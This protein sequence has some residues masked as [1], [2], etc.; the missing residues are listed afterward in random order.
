MSLFCW[1]MSSFLSFFPKNNTWLELLRHTVSVQAYSTTSSWHFLLLMPCTPAVTGW[2]HCWAFTQVPVPQ[3]EHVGLYLFISASVI[4]LSDFF[5]LPM[6]YSTLWQ[7]HIKPCTCRSSSLSA[8]HTGI[9]VISDAGT[10]PLRFLIGRAHCHYI[11]LQQR[12]G[13]HQR[14]KIPSLSSTTSWRLSRTMWFTAAYRKTSKKTPRL[15]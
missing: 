11:G 3:N 7:A 14:L 9:V 2:A 5:N 6:Q 15:K 12:R 8:T 13:L 1:F 4:N 10:I